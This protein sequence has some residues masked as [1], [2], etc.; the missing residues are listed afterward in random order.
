MN[1]RRKGE[2][3]TSNTEFMTMTYF[4]QGWKK[5]NFMRY[6]GDFCRVKAN[7]TNSM[8]YLEKYFWL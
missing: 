2:K 4:V 8:A 5:A 7:S 1:M 6:L 3:V